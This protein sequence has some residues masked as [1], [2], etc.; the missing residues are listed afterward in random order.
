MSDS[1]WLAHAVRAVRALLC[2]IFWL[3]EQS[4]PL[5]KA[6]RVDT[7]C[8]HSS[9]SPT[10]RDAQNH[11]TTLGHV[12]FGSTRTRNGSEEIPSSTVE[13][14]SLCKLMEDKIALRRQS[15]ASK[16]M[17]ELCLL[18]E[19]MGKGFRGPKISRELCDLI[20]ILK[21]QRLRHRKDAGAFCRAGGV[22][23][24]VRM[25]P[26]CEEARDRVLLLSTI[27]NV[28]WLD[29]NTRNQVCV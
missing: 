8:K 15:Y 12:M 17:E 20:Y 10:R 28:C 25:L 6:S 11:T 1:F 23:S 22:S 21:T 2:E 13:R 24:L 4:A 5:Q 27:A 14:H 16:A 26:V 3:Q 7:L 9:F 19:S 18:L 29:C